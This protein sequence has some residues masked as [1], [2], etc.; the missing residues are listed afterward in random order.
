MDL[1]YT[2][3]YI[4]SETERLIIR[5]MSVNDFDAL[6]TVLAD[7]DIMQHYPYTFDRARVQNWIN[8]N[9]Q[10]YQVFGFGLWAI[11]LKST[12][13]MIGDCG[14][15]MQKID[16]ETLPEIGYH[17]A[18]AYQRQGYA[19]EAAKFC[20]DM[21]FECTDFNT[22]YSYMKKNNIASALTARAIGMKF[23]KQ[24]TDNENEQ[25]IVY[26]ITR[27]EWKNLRNVKKS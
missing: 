17:I 18:K 9:I 12:G 11:C 2:K 13:E 10:R 7:S 3:F 15:T 8:V 25:S 22:I 24:Y 26:S 19:S 5:K 6:Y 4:P 1:M 16:N 23:S 27:S 21:T 14:L 20:R